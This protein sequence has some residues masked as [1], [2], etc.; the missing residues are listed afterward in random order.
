MTAPTFKL[1]GTYYPPG[2]GLLAVF[3]SESEARA[4]AD[5]HVASVVMF[6]FQGTALSGP[7]STIQ[8][9]VPAPRPLTWTGTDTSADLIRDAIV[10]TEGKCDIRL[11]RRL[12]DVYGR[13]LTIDTPQRI[14]TIKR[15][16][17]VVR[18][19]DG[20]VAGPDPLEGA[21]Q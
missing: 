19:A 10:E 1:W 17:T 16:G 14:F 8:Q 11:D 18:A 13:E 6:E 3:P 12:T 9:Q 7:E 15:G 4:H 21:T 5:E 20:W 2:D